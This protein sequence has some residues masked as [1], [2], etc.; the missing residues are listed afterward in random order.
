M[1]DNQKGIVEVMS[2]TGLEA[3]EAAEKINA[4]LRK[5]DNGEIV[6]VKRKNKKVVSREE[7]KLNNKIRKKLRK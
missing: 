6:V 2:E 4:S 5:L 3:K 1:L 7:R